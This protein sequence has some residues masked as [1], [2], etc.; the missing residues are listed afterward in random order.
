MLCVSP[1][2]TS[3]KEIAELS[4]DFDLVEVRLDLNSFSIDEVKKIFNCSK[5]L[6]AV[7]R[8][9]IMD[10][11]GREKRLIEAVKNGSALIDIEIES[12]HSYMKRL[13]DTALQY[14][15]KKIFSYHNYR[16][17]PQK[18]ELERIAGDMFSA[19]ADIAKIA[20]SV[21]TSEDISN[22]L[23]LYGK[24]KNIIA[25]GMGYQGRITR[26][27]GEILGAP[28]TYTSFRG[29]GTAEGQFDYDEMANLLKYFNHA[30]D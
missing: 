3:V 15:C 23:S 26:L 10:D 12:E 22:I 19:G 24:F 28:V 2:K 16:S 5:N 1:G 4:S 13:M 20:C 18:D 30:L 11:T 8:P 17:T 27:V 9:G 14:N 7:F 25:T 6:I 29:R 21:K